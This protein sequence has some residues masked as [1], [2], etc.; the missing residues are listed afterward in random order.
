MDLVF[1]DIKMAS[2]YFCKRHF[3]YSS[4]I[5]LQLKGMPRSGKQQDYNQAEG[6]GG[7]GG[8]S[9]QFLPK[10]SVS[11]EVVSDSQSDEWKS[12]SG[13]F[14]LLDWHRFKFLCILFGIQ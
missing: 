9:R 10:S 4:L 3:H 6:Y 5:F 14:V 8:K 12:N 11:P 7:G 2:T 1:D 13:A